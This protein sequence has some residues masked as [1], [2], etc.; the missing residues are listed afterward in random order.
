MNPEF[1]SPLLPAPCVIEQGILVNKEDMQRVLND[2]GQVNYYYQLDGKCQAEGQGWILDVFSDAQQATIVTNQ[3][4]YLNVNS[5]D[6]LEIS[7]D[8]QGKTIVDLW[9]ESRHLRLVPLDDWLNPREGYSQLM[10]LDLEEAVAEVLA[11]RLDVQR[12]EEDF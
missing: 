12:D 3:S 11:A 5:F 7:L 2:L 6:Y 1:H 4:L 8:H 9:Q 10:P